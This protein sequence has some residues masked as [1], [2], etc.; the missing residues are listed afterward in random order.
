MLAAGEEGGKGVSPHGQPICRIM[1]SRMYGLANTDI[2]F[3]RYWM[4]SA[5]LGLTPIL[6][7]AVA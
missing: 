6:E 3:D 1:C 4:S 2:I 7:L 5:R